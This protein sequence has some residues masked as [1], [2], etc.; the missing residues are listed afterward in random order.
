MAPGV[1][2]TGM[3]RAVISAIGMLFVPAPHRAI[4]RTES[5]TSALCSLWLRSRMAWGSSAMPPGSEPDVP[6]SAKPLPNSLSP[7]GLIALNVC[8]WKLG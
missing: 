6:V 2:K 1:L 7:T 3:P 8:T 4:A 5:A